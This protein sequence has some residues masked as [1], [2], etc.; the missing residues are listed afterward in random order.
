MILNHISIGVSDLEKAVSFYDAVLETL[1]INRT[2]YIENAAAAYGER[3]EFWIGYPIEGRATS[4]N[5]VHVALNAPSKDA[6]M[7]FYKTALELGGQCEGQPGPRPE[8]GE[9]YFAAF[10]RDLDG[11]KLEAVFLQ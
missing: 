6:V 11:N 1:S 8:Y 10:V 5:G 4:G 3:F 2:H 7:R 9:T